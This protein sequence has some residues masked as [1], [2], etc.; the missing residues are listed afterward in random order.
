M[1]LS[2]PLPD[3][4]LIQCILKAKGSMISPRGKPRIPTNSFKST[5]AQLLTI[6]YCNTIQLILLDESTNIELMQQ[7]SMLIT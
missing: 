5:F 4:I 2:Y 7:G 3:P 1:L 6:V